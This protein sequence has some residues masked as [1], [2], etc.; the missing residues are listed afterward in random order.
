MW[1]ATHQIELA[2]LMLDL[3]VAL[4]ED[5]QLTAAF[6]DG[7]GDVEGQVDTL[8]VYQARDHGEQR[9]MALLEPE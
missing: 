6:D 3:V 7:M 8:L 4:A 5:R 1:A 2:N 9:C